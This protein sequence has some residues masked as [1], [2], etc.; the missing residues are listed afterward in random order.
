[1]KYWMPQG[2]LGSRVQNADLHVAYLSLSQALTA[3]SRD[4]RLPSFHDLTLESFSLIP[5]RDLTI[6]IF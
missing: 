2:L 3:G 1:M 4:K 6:K 5:D